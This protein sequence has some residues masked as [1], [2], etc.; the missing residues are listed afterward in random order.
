[1]KNYFLTIL[2]TV[3]FCSASWSQQL[4]FP[5]A[6]GYGKYTTGG[7]GGAVYEVTNLNSSG[8][9]S[10]GA[11][12]AASGARTIV[13]RV[14]GTIVGNFSIKNGDL[15]I[16]G[17]TAPGDG[18]C[19]RG[20]L[21]TE[22]ANNIIIRY[23]RVR[24][25]PA[26][27]ANDALGGRYSKNIIFD[28]VS[29]SWSTDEVL[30]L[31]HNENTTVQWCMITEACEKYEN[32]QPI[33]HRFGGIWGNNYGTWHHN[34]LA[35][36]D[37]RNVRWAS[38]CRF[39]D[40]RNNVLY[41]PGYQGAYGGESV[42]VGSE[43]TYSFTTINIIAN[44]YKA[45]PATSSGIKYQIA[46]PSARSSTDK[47][48]WYV[49]GNYVEGS[50]SVTGNNWQGMTGGNYIAM[51][52]PWEAMPIRQESAVDAYNSV[53]AKAGCSFPV[54][55][56]VDTRIVEETRTG[57]STYGRNGIINTPADV[58]GWPSLNSKEAPL[59]TDRDGMPDSW[60]TANG[61]NPNDASDRNG[62]GEGG[63]TNLEVYLYKLVGE[64]GKVSGVSVF[65][66]SGS[67]GI[68][69]TLQLNTLVAPYGA[70]NQNVNWS[71]SN[72]GVARVSSTGLVTGV[73]MG[74]ATITATTVDGEFKAQ[75]TISVSSIPVSGITMSQNTLSVNVGS[76]G[77]LTASVVP[78]SA[79]NQNISWSSGN[80]AVATVDSKGLVSGV[81]AGT[82][83][84]T[85]TSS[86]GSFKVQ[87]AVTVIPAT[88]YQAESFTSKTA[89][90]TVLSSF[91][92]YTGSGYVDM[93][94]SGDWFEWNNIDGGSGGSTSLIF[95]YANG[96]S[97]DRQ[98]A[99]N[100]NGVAVGNL[101]F[102]TTGSWG[103]WLT[104]SITANLNA[105]NNTVRV[106]VNTANGGPNLDYVNVSSGV[107]GIKDLAPTEQGNSTL[108]QNF[109]NPFNGIT[110]ISYD[111][112]S[113]GEV[114]LSVY[115]GMGKH[116]TTLVNHWQ[117]AGKHSVRFD[118]G[119]LLGGVYY[120]SLRTGSTEQSAKMLL[121]K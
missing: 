109:P 102:S 16:A 21:S 111:L 26:N 80:T 57:T 88:I 56:A 81:S 75:T 70:S 104:Q 48:S 14:S 35:N 79:S 22:K 103:I 91:A 115:D 90:N 27:G 54:R 84:I 43:A 58:G 37:S 40:Y 63:Y 44:Y 18:I 46:A 97:T 41:N 30:T 92:G 76:A 36:N 113:Q 15:T 96:G 117:D 64:G 114:N 51:N 119:S 7:R 85:A 83:V 3:L 105:G 101:S 55:D 94:N 45:G 11:A 49:S 23:I 107:T 74:S 19:I 28:H 32:G 112:K 29:A 72:S 42:Q 34:L 10:F 66:S 65:P 82:A 71:S 110:T 59:D 98:C 50:P 93:G 25:D 31:Y 121:V 2:V 99:I 39:N 95:R 53:L 6:E 5:T 120:M 9:G 106:T 33:G 67:L 89:G 62:I 69:N 78:S 108:L 87:C 38:G 86:E 17:Q 1:M 12:I 13:F 20:N 73:A 100:V 118:A 4:A 68:N 47:G 24:F 52:A 77:Q 61:L 60:E 8:P 116:I